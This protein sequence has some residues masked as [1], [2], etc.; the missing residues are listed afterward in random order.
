MNDEL[1]VHALP[2]LHTVTIRPVPTSGQAVVLLH[3]FPLD[4]RMWL[5]AA[6]ALADRLAKSGQPWGVV[7]LDL[8]GLGRSGTAEVEPSLTTS[9]HVVLETLTA[10]GITD[11]V[12]AGVSMGGYVTMEIA[13]LA[14]DGLRAIALVDTKDT[15]DAPEARANRLRIADEV[16]QAASVASVRPMGAAQL[17]P[18]HRD[19][20]RILDTVEGWIDEQ[21]PAG[22]AWSQRAMAARGDYLDLT[23][24]LAVPAVVIVGEHDELSPV[25]GAQEMA[26]RAHVEHVVVSDAGHL[27]AFEQPQQVAAALGDL[28][29]QIG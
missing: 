22:V 27:A 16:T 17:A 5:P 7:A 4:H 1:D 3:A 8:P 18:A 10:L 29:D 11:F 2:Q 26:E 14:P 21:P 23:K 6:E 9:A 13:R 24:K 28:L 19:E 20:P 12:I 25:A 15:G